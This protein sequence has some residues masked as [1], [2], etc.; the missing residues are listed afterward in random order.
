[1]AAKPSVRPR[2]ASSAPVGAIVEPSSGKK[3]VGY[4]PGERPPAEFDNW[5]QNLNYQWIDYLGDQNFSGDITITGGDLIL[6]DDIKYVA[7]RDIWYPSG[8]GSV[9]VGTGNYNGA[10]WS[11]LTTGG[12]YVVVTPL[13]GLRVGDRLK[14]VTVYGKEGNAAGE[15]YSAVIRRVFPTTNDTIGGTKT[16]GVT[17][18][19]TSIGWTVADTDFTPNGHTIGSNGYQLEVTVAQT[20][21]LTEVLYRCAQVTFDRPP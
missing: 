19:N 9:L 16:S 8:A 6:E 7:V 5:L 15:T 20:S 12:G 18:G 17:N 13:T 2:W 21:A 11:S 1:M 4:E 10:F 3:D 14:T